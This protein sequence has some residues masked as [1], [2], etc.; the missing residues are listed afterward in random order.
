MKGLEYARFQLRESHNQ[1]VHPKPI[2]V[3]PQDA[4]LA[5][6]IQRQQ[7]CENSDCPSKFLILC[8]KSIQSALQQDV[9]FNFKEDKPLF[10]NEWGV[11]FW[12]CYSSGIDVL[13]T[14][15]ACSTLERIAWM[16]STAADTIARKEKEGIFLTGL[17]L[18]FLVPSQE[19]AAKARAV[20][21]P[22]KALRIHTMSLHHGASL[23]QPSWTTSASFFDG[24]HVGRTILFFN[25]HVVQK[26]K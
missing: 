2:C 3:S 21:K 13:E 12:K 15:G 22:L 23:D 8:L 7:S 18:L 11:E 5:A 26:G 25:S 19:E 24:N 9:I 1:K 6:K 20:C 10:V 14:S 16:I 4:C 17:F